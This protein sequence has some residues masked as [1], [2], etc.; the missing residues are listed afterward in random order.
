MTYFDYVKQIFPCKETEKF[1]NFQ[2]F[3]KQLMNKKE[4]LAESLYSAMISYGIGREI[5]FI[6]EEEISSNLLTLK[7]KDFLA[8]DMIFQVVQSKLFRTK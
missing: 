4:K 3:K 5:E 6:D 2:E 8:K 7:E 1:E